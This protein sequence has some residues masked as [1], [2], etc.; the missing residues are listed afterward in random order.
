MQQT[1]G[2]I[3]LQERQPK[4]RIV[5][6]PKVSASSLF[7]FFKKADY[8]FES[9]ENTAL[10]PRFYEERIDYL[11]VAQSKVAYPMVCFCDINMHLLA[12]HVDFYGK[13]GLVFSKE[14]GCK[15]KIQPIHYINPDSPLCDDFSTAFCKA[16]DQK[17]D[18]VSSNYLLSHMVY[19]K[20]LSGK[21]LRDG[22]D[23]DRVFYDER[24]WRY[25]PSAIGRTDIPCVILEEYLYMQERWNKALK[26]RPETWL[27]FEPSDIRYIIIEG[28]YDFDA[29]C[30]VIGKVA[31]TDRIK[32]QLLSKIIIWDDIKEDF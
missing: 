5:P 27:R 16:L 13:Y 18:S 7:R 31:T 1:P 4:E 15:N 32:N 24:E 23:I 19:M 26:K 22:K 9:L 21:M 20:P 17:E 11:K 3:Q 29:I 25:I 2:V 8:L 14:W 28:A 6:P 30:S 10:I 12:S